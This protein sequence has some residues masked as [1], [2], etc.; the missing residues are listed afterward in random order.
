MTGRW[1]LREPSWQAAPVPRW[2]PLDDGD[3]PRV[4]IEHPD[5]AAQEVLASAFRDRGYDVLSCGGPRAQGMTEVHCPLLEEGACPAVDGADA[6]VT[7][8]QV[9][10]GAEGDVVSALLADP[11]A[12]PVLLEASAWQLARAGLPEDPA[13]RRWPFRCPEAV[14]DEVEGFVLR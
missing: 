3:A 1:L 7:S 6:V 9:G 5:P 14:V 11:L 13:G 8:L 2:A 10:A 12:P 4:L